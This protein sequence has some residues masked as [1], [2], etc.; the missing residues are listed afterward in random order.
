MADR[1]LIEGNEAVALGLKLIDP[2]V[3]AAYPI[4]PATEVV[5]K[6]SEYVANGDVNTEFVAVESEHSAMSACIA[7]SLAGGR[8][9]TA[10]SAQ[11][12]AL[13]WEMLYIASSLRAPVIMAVANRA[14]SG[15]I[16]IHCD[17]SDTMG[18]RDAGWIHLFSENTQ[19]I[20][21]NVI[22]AVRIAEHPDVRLPVMVC[23]DGFVISHAR[24]VIDGLSK[25]EVQSFVGKYEPPAMML[26][27]KPRTYGPLD[28]QDFYFEHKR[29]LVEVY[30][31]VPSVVE[32]TGK[33]FGDKFGRYYG[34][35]EEYKMD[36]AEVALVALGST[37]GTIKDVVD[38][39][40]ES[41]K[42][43]GLLKVRAFRPFP[44][45]LIRKAL[46]GVKAV[47]VFDRSVTF[48]GWGNPVWTEVRS[49]MYGSA[50]GCCSGPCIPIIDRVYG[51]G[52]REI[53]MAQIE[54]Y[55][56]EVLAAAKGEDVP[57]IDFIGVRE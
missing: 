32:Q 48:G 18:A 37:N 28:L 30:E 11:G 13:M 43:V 41:G 22:Q 23:Y 25:D 47:G 38:G 45:E 1:I 7:A 49:A 44:A 10:T 50:N 29:G 12:L 55:A 5:Q 56:D 9:M 16:N 54:G 19:E 8:V 3:V 52:G 14:L 31:A 46:C 15:N 35:I 2:D 42:K 20:F 39:L 33:E 34:Q 53:T 21:D 27:M 4:T 40:W 24:E 6:F 51:L 26:D 17:H 57:L 36:G